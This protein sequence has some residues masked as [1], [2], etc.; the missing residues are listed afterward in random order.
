MPG[1]FAFAEA[2]EGELRKVAQ[3]VVTAARQL[4]D[5]TGEPGHRGV[6]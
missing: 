5:Q 4:A 6:H 3:E 1:I 2:R